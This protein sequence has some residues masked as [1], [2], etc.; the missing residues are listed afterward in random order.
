VLVAVLTWAFGGFRA[1][2]DVGRPGVVGEEVQL[3]RWVIAVQGAEYS[4]KTLNGVGSD[5][6]VRVRLRFTNTTDATIFSFP[7]RMVTVR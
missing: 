3:N 5:P 6:V 1:A 4:S 7:D 2:L